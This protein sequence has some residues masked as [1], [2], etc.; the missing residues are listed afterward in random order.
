MSNVNSLPRFLTANTIKPKDRK[1]IVSIK[2]GIDLLDEQI[3]GL[4]KGEVSVISGLNGSGK[5]SLLSQV[6]LEIVNMGKKVALF[7]G[8]LESARVLDWIMLQAAGKWNTIGSEK[9]P[10]Y[11][12]V[13]ESVKPDI[14]EWFEQKLFI[15][16]N[17][18]GNRV[19]EIMD[20]ISHCII[21]KGV[22]L[23]ILDNLMAIDLGSSTY[24]KMEKQSTFMNAV[25]KFAKENFVHISLV[26]HPRKT[27][28]FL[29]KD[30]ISG[31]A[32]L[33][34]MA[35]NVFIVHRVNEDFKRL[36]KQTFNWKA[37]HPIYENSN[38]IEVCKNRDLGVQDF[39]VGLHFEKETKRF[40]NTLDEEK[41]Y[42]WEDIVIADEDIKM[43]FDL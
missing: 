35:D 3:I 31:T 24:D 41:H 4:N 12:Y 13:R 16:N 34:N 28:G 25:S 11:F 33:T 26:A 38:V 1:D 30:D 40:K 9:Y 8:E 6:A 10:N 18:R 29:R 15:Y 39:F 42:G 37:D 5:S 17:N 32:D 27:I 23:V 43:P 7:S 19:D 14:K 20:S 21:H 22:D 2:T 36:S